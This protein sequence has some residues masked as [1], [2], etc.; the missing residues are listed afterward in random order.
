MAPA[1]YWLLR[2]DEVGIQGIQQDLVSGEMV[3]LYEVARLRRKGPTGSG[4]IGAKSLYK[5]IMAFYTK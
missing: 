3:Y 1:T 4:A 5:Y 2:V